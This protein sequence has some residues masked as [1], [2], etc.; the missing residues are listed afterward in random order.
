MVSFLFIQNS[1]KID[2]LLSARSP[3][4]NPE[5]L[6]TKRSMYFMSERET[7]S[8]GSSCKRDARFPDEFI[9]RLIKKNFA[10]Y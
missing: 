4:K 3:K 6:S 8:T 10:R 1:S 5:H 2:I 9:C 7:G